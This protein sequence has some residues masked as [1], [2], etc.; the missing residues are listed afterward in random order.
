MLKTALRYRMQT[1]LVIKL[2]KY[3]QDLFMDTVEKYDGYFAEE[4]YWAV[5]HIIFAKGYADVYSDSAEKLEM[6]LC[7]LKK[8]IIDCLA[9]G[10]NE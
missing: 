7:G 9:R 8:L 4:E 1:N 3:S 6:R 2:S 10:R 5:Y